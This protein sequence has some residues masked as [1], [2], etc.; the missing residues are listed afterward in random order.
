MC[1]AIGGVVEGH[2]DEVWW[3]L[4][5]AVRREVQSGEEVSLDTLEASEGMKF[6]LWVESADEDYHARFGALDVQ[7][8]PVPFGPTLVGRV[9]YVMYD[10]IRLGKDVIRRPLRA[11]ASS[12]NDA[13]QASDVPLSEI[14][15]G[16]DSAY[17]ANR[18]LKPIVADERPGNV[19]LHSTGVPLSQ[20][21][22]ARWGQSGAS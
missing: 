2:R 8:R 18:K 10:R 21:Y 7:Q 19:A 20:S 13:V 9:K 15:H 16:M 6:R 3:A 5:R 17:R 4:H 14:G 12:L 1:H 22:F 11:D